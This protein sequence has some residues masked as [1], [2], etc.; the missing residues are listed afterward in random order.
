MSKVLIIHSQISGNGGIPRFNRNL[1]QAVNDKVT[2]SLNDSG[3]GGYNR[4]KV[5]FA[6]AVIGHSLKLRPKTI[7]LGHLNFLPLAVIL[8]LLN[9]NAKI[10]TLL[11]GIEAWSKQPFTKIL[12]EFVYQFWAVSSYTAQTFGRVNKIR[13]NKVETIFNTLPAQWPITPG[14]FGNSILSVTRLDKEEGYK[15]I[16]LAISAV[17]TTKEL[18]RKMNLNYIIVASGNDV[19]RHQELVKK[20]EITDLVHFKSRVSDEKLIDL[21]RDCLFF[22][23]PS[24]GEGFGIVYLEAMA[25]GKP[26]IGSIDCGAE[27]VIVD[28]E[29]GF[30]INQT[31]EDIAAKLEL[32]IQDNELCR[33]QGMLG[34]KRL[35]DKFTFDRFKERITSLLEN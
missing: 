15:G 9:P 31:V 28:G 27:D 4:N 3:H 34:M 21:Y 20:L 33:K 1:E 16:D 29:T 5:K 14:E 19:E 30:L 10:I 32:L 7:I 25:F 18:M 12:S 17:S 13:L 2:I 22:L 26:C 6:L 8:K 24:T 35:N 11:H 23:L